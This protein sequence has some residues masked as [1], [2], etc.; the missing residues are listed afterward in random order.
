MAMIQVEH[1]TF[2]YEDSPENVFEDISFRLD[3]DWKLGLIARNGKGKTTMLR[4]LMGQLEYRGSISMPVEVEY[5]PP[6]IKEK[7]Q[8]AVE[9]AESVNPSCEL[10]K[11]FRECNLLGLDTEILYRPFH[12]LS[13]GEQTKV[14]LAGL[15]AG[16]GAFLLIDEPT[17]HLDSEARETIGTYLKHKRGFILVSHDRG[18]LDECVDHVMVMNR[19]DMEIRQGNFSD[20]WQDKTNRDAFEIRENEKLKKEIGRLQTAARQSKNWADKVE[21]TKI[22]KDPL[23][24][25]PARAY[26]GEKSRKMQMRRKNIERRQERAIEEKQK[27]LRNVEE[28]ENL[29]LMPLVHHKPVLAEAKGCTLAYTSQMPDCPRK[30]AVEDFSFTLR[31]GEKIFLRGK[32]GCG[33]STILKAVM[34]QAWEKDGRTQVWEEECF[35][36]LIG[37]SLETAAGLAL[38]YVPQDASFLAGSLREY[39]RISGIEETIFF[40]LLRKLDFSREQLGYDME[41]YSAGQKKKVLLARSLCSQAHLYIWDEPLNYIDV[42]SRLQIEELLRNSQFTLLAVEHD[43]AFCRNIGG[44]EVLI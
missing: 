39:A 13:N 19:Q 29:K 27:L 17:N 11:F 28:P 42:F 3:T 44:R 37:G 2:G 12:T 24:D 25:T 9:T 41:N 10:W 33:K 6:E 36:E 14:L 4:L 38:S 15:F 26:I 20:W 35:P 32:N 5:F 18:L 34:A 43:K 30:A 7:G 31:R 8:L 22:G 40:T 1:L 23:A 21:S 16:E